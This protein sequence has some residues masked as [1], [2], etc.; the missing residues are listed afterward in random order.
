MDRT[1]GETGYC[2]TGSSAKVSS[3]F[4]HFGEEQVL[5]GT[6][7]SGAV[8][9][10]ECNLRCVFCQNHGISHGGDGR[11]VTVEELAGLLTGLEAAG[12]H[13]VN[14]VT[15]SHV[16]PQVFDA[17]QRART[18]GLAIPVVY[19]TSAYDRVDTLR[20]LD[21]LV[22]I[23][24]PDFKFWSVESSTAWMDAG[25]Y[26]EVARAAIAEMHRQVGDL[27]LDRFGIAR[28][29]LMVRHLV[30]PGGIEDTVAIMGFLASLSPDTFVNLMAQY[31][32]FDGTA[33]H[34]ELDRRPLPEEMNASR[35]AALDAGLH[36]LAR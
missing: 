26:P 12:C 36:R 34:Q 8:F 7:G 23:Y 24:M 31:R 19:N 35:R 25:D 16:V 32:P 5:V 11:E 29:G 20:H 17:L 2:R 10:S 4:P 13:N 30:M 3:A 9:F 15:P 28:R 6:R 21:G 14:F 18:R 22:D 27:E 33:R 1:S